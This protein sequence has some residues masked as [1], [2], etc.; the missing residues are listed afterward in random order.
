MKRI[1][2]ILAMAAAAQATAI[3]YTYQSWS[4]TEIVLTGYSGVVPANLT[5]PSKIDGK[6]VV[7]IGESFMEECE[8]LVSLTFPSTIR[9]VGEWAFDSCVNLNALH[10]NEG[11]ETVGA[12]AFRKLRSLM[13]LSLPSTLREIGEG[14]FTRSNEGVVTEGRRAGINTLSIHGGD[15]DWFSASGG[16]LYDKVNKTVVMAVTGTGEITIPGG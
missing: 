16:V 13:S 14:A 15:N 11:L 1:L 8:D 4:S 12:K 10:L 9:F 6:T 7:G 5:I 3:T 2:A